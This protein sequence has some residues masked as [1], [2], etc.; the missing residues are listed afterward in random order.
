MSVFR[1]LNIFRTSCTPLQITLAIV[2]GLLM[3]LSP[4]FLNLQNVLLSLL[5]LFFRV[6]WRHF[7]ASYA[8]TYL[9]GLVVFDRI[10]HSLGLSI[11]QVEGLQAFYGAIY[12]IPLIPLTR[13]NNSV[14]C[15]ALLVSAVSFPIVYFLVK[16]LKPAA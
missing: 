4:Q 13:F 11:L 2:V 14:I 6:P 1:Y 16:R 12:K 8:I 3:G 15:G 9:L 10:L 7:L 5:L